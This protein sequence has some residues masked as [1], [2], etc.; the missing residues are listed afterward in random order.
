MVFPISYYLSIVSKT[1]F[2]LTICTW[3]QN[4]EAVLTL[5]R[6]IPEVAKLAKK[7]EKLQNSSNNSNSVKI[8]CIS[9]SF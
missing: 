3:V 8:K 1:K 6:E 4:C 2:E 9:V 5:R 7:V